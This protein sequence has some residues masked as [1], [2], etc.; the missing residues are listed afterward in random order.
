MAARFMLK[1]WLISELCCVCVIAKSFKAE[2]GGIGGRQYNDGKT[3]ADL[4]IQ[5]PVGTVVH[6]LDTK[7]DKEITK[8]GEKMMVAQG[9]RGERVI[10]IFVHQPTPAPKNFKKAKPEKNTRSD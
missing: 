6:N 7:I 4:I 9:G 3:G 5:V 8:I 1:G 10:I 2:D